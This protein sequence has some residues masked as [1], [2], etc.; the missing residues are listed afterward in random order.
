MWKCIVEQGKERFRIMGSKEDV[1]CH[2]EEALRQYSRVK[3]I[4]M[5]HQQTMIAQYAV[6]MLKMAVLFLNFGKISEAV[7]HALEAL[8]IF[9]ANQAN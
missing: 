8:E 7:N 6:I 2:R 3:E 1:K 9:D 4:L 5:A